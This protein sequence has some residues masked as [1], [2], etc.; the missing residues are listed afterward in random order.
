VST[1]PVPAT[2]AG[3]EGLDAVRADLGRA[4]V[5]LDFDGTL[6]PIVLDPADAR[7]VDGGLA[8]LRRLAAVAGTVAVITG[9]AAAT[10]VALGG[11]DTVPGLVVEGQYGAEQWRDGRLR[12][13]DPPPGIAAVRAEL[14]GALAAA[15]V[16]PGVWVEDKKLALVVHTR[17]ASDP[18]GALAALAE[19]VGRLATTHG[20]EP[21]SGRYVL[22]LRPPGLDKG[23]TLRRLVAEHHPAAVLF[24]GDDL[25]DLPAFAAVERLREA[26]TPGVTVCSASAEAAEV[27]ERADLVVDG[28]AGVV[29]LLD[30]LTAA[31]PSA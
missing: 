16:D 11:L 19:P 4:L 13:P 7:L 29:G 6:S 15:G 23:G 26:G 24:A 25:G 22:E 1:I 27:A 2:A 30:A 5:A 9:R 31:P 17:R 21:H 18:A 28:P 8:A 20:L 10:V 12:V 14:P 3:R